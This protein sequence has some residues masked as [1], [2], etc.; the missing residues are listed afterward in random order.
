M[1]SR[2]T[3]YQDDAAL[4]SAIPLLQRK[5]SEQRLHVADVR[6]RLDSRRPSHSG[7]HRI[8]R[9]Q[10]W[11]AVVGRHDDGHLDA[12][13]KS[14]VD[15]CSEAFEEC[16]LSAV[17][18]RLPARICPRTEL[19]TDQRGELGEAIEAGPGRIAMADPR[20]RL[21]AEP[22]R[23]PNGCVTETSIDPRCFDLPADCDREMPSAVG[24]NVMPASY[25]HPTESD[26][27]AL[28][29]NHRA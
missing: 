18:E 5:A 3:Q 17:S 8:P 19:E 22:Q 24:S 21:T 7:H 4:Q 16:S 10:V 14:G 2:I 15:S 9:A 13:S 23:P 1:V 28:L 27:G 11:T 29:R 25:R 6:L 12:P 26:E 20:N